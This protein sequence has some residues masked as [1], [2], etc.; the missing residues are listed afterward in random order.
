MAKND[1]DETLIFGMN[2]PQAIVVVVL[3][4]LALSVLG[5]GPFA[6]DTDALKSDGNS[7]C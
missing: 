5:Y 7:R 6:E 4:A 2:V 1:K 3:A